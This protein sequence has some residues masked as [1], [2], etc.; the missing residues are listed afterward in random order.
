VLKSRVF[1]TERFSPES[2]EDRENLNLERGA[3]LMYGKKY[4]CPEC[5]CKFYDLNK[6][7]AICPKCGIEYKEPA[8]SAGDKAPTRRRKKIPPPVAV[9][10]ELLPPEEKV[11]EEFQGTD[12]F[13]SLSDAEGEDLG[14]DTDDEDSYDEE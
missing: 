11:D 8:K 1:N 10:E 5:G 13:T 7:Q 3:N 9:A 14:E 12:D 2:R 4:T 6:P